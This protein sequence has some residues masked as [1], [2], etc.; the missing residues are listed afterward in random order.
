MRRTSLRGLI[1]IYTTSAP[2]E[3]P[4]LGA[5]HF[6]RG[7]IAIYTTSAPSESPRLGAVHFLTGL[8][9]IYA[10]AAP[11]ESPGLGAVPLGRRIFETF[12]LHTGPGVEAG[13]QKFAPRLGAVNF[14]ESRIRY[15]RG[16]R[17]PPT[18][19]A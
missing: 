3:S 15:L 1:A 18:A 10:T 4:G 6:L 7:L 11:S 5:V 17:A 12:A 13:G 14:F 9:A 8:I 2:S 16:A 19:P